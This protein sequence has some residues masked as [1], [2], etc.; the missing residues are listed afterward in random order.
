MGWAQTGTAEAS[1]PPYYW[2]L[3][4]DLNNDGAVNFVDVGHYVD[5]WLDAGSELPPDLDRNEMVDLTDYALL[6]QNCFS[7]TSW[8]E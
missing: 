1:M 6:G 5:Y 2:A 4:A 3:L 8:H 7:Q